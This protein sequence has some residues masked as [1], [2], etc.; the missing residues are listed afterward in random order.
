MTVKYL[1]RKH[2]KIHSFPCFR[3]VKYAENKVDLLLKSKKK[4]SQI[5]LFHF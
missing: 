1:P 5:K 4:N 2:Q 3:G